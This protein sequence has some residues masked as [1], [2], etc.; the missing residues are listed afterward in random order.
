MHRVRNEVP[1]ESAVDDKLSRADL[2]ASFADRILALDASQGLVIGILGPWG[3]GKTSF[4]NLCREELKDREV[5][6][7]DFNPWMFAGAD[8]L[9][10]HFFSELSGQLRPRRGLRDVANQIAGYGDLLSGAG[11]IPVAGPW[12]ER[13]RLALKMISKSTGGVEGGV[14]ATRSKI[15]AALRMLDVPIVVV[16][17]DIDRLSTAEIRDVFRLVR[18]TASFPNIIYLVAFDRERVESALEEDGLPGRAYLEKI[19]QMATDLPAVPPATLQTE[20]FEALGAIVAG[21]DWLSD[22]DQK[23]WADVYPTIVKPLIGNLRDVRRFALGVEPAVQ[24]FAGQ[25]PLS[26]VLGL[27]AIR[28]FVPDMFVR[29]HD[30]A[31]ALTGGRGLM[32]ANPAAD[33]A[34]IED[35]VNAAGPSNEAVARSAVSQFFPAARKHLGGGAY[36]S[37]WSSTWRAAHKVAHRDNLMLYLEHVEGAALASFNAGA[38]AFQVGRDAAD[39]AEALSGISEEVKVDAIG[40]LLDFS[41][42]FEPE[43]VYAMCPH[44]LNT[45]PNL[46]KVRAGFFELSGARTVRIVVR[47]L[48]KSLGESPS[49]VE[50]IER[51]LPEIGFIGGERLLLSAAIDM[52]ANKSLVSEDEATRLWTNWAVRL[53]Q[54]GPDVLAREF[55]LFGDLWQ[56]HS[57]AEGLGRGESEAC[58]AWSLPRDAGVS[59]SVLRSATWVQKS[60]S[61]GTVGVQYTTL[62]HWDELVRLLGSEDEVAERLE[63]AR[64]KLAEGEHLVLEAFDRYLAGWRPEH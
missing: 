11:W 54:Q 32:L 29:L 7:L 55:D 35:L 58:E 53:R 44:L 48:L 34:K 46:P 36:G 50:G 31:D 21:V 24:R 56:M 22:G 57:N 37:E 8:Q 62:V 25:L 10:A 40:A 61:T 26:E 17:D 59:A 18:L 14:N 23:Q 13:L 15:V 49:V 52:E 47:G 41:E 42:R 4:I 2:A 16:L 33:K 20:T 60:E 19:V 64:D 9:V 6:T 28:I 12:I 39:F 1:I 43:H 38:R 30:A 45:I 5:T 63:A 27:E 51:L 3:S